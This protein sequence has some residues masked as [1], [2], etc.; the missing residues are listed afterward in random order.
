MCLRVH[1]PP[2]VWTGTGSRLM[3]GGQQALGYHFLSICILRPV[4]VSR[5]HMCAKFLV[6]FTERMGER[7]VG[8]ELL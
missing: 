5:F 7:T 1:S 4:V 2:V 3:G 6:D 8:R